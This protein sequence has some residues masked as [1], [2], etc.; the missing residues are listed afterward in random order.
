MDE[1]ERQ[2]G[3]E[4]APGKPGNRLWLQAV[5]RNWRRVE[6]VMCPPFLS[7]REA[8]DVVRGFRSLR[9]IQREKGQPC[10]D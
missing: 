2:R 7:M 10:S 5:D 8:D 1:V 6:L 9:Q 4:A 3:R